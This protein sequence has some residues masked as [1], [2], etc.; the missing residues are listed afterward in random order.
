MGQIKAIDLAKFLAAILV[1]AIHT[2]PFDGM[3][4][5]YYFTCFCRI[6]V[7]FFFVVSSYFFWRKPDKSIRSYTKRLCTIY[8]VWFLIELPIV[9][10]RFFV[11]FEYSLPLQI[12][13][14]FRSLIFSNTFYASWYLM[15]SIIAMNMVW[16]LSKKLNNKQLL[17]LA[18]GG[19]VL[20][21][22]SAGYY[23]ITDFPAW[24][25]IHYF[26]SWALAPANSFIIALIYVVIGKIIA[27]NNMEEWK[28][29]S[30]VHKAILMFVIIAILGAVEITLLRD[31]AKITDAFVFL[32]FLTFVGVI[33]LL[34]INVTIPNGLARFFRNSSI[35][36]YLLHSIFQSHL[37]PLFNM[38]GCGMMSFFVTTAEC[39]VASILIISI[40]NKI[41][42]L[43]YLY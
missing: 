6:A 41:K 14:F 19:Y 28:F 33:I 25:N 22:I 1:V 9:Y 31:S 11:D 2:H 3:D 26:L 30:S 5:D 29:L 23:G 20:S 24:S 17:V 32:P 18:G 37:N 38:G 13:N 12:L 15:A 43:K 21:L 8:L 27:Q 10:H 40:S 16:W 4:V 7:P 34:R 36:I 39:I 35:L 42:L